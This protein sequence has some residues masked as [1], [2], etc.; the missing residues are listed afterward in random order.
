MR[1]AGDILLGQILS[2]WNGGR[3]FI[4]TLATKPSL[5]DVLL[6]D[7]ASLPDFRGRR[8]DFGCRRTR[9]W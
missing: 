9:G 6:Q 8:V 7:K 3:L 4:L 1:P 5:A 2:L